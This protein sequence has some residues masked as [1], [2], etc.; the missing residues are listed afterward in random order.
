M[1]RTVFISQQSA[2]LGPVST[3]D[4]TEASAL[5]PEACGVGEGSGE[6]CEESVLEPSGHCDLHGIHGDV[7]R[8]QLV[9]KT[10]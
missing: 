5:F 1:A 4:I 3:R 7:R 2:E 9:A 8:Q 10:S 6:Y